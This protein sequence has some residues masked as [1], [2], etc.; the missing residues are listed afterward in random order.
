MVAANNDQQLQI[1]STS[2]MKTKSTPLVFPSIPTSNSSVVCQRGA[3]RWRHLRDLVACVAFGLLTSAG[4]TAQSDYFTALDDTD[5]GLSDLAVAPNGTLIAVGTKYFTEAGTGVV[6]VSWNGGKD[7]VERVPDPQVS[8]Y[9]AV[10]SGHRKIAPATA[11]DLATFEDSI[12]IA[13][14]TGTGRWRVL[15]SLNSG[16]DWEQIEDFADPN[17]V[18]ELFC[19]TMDNEGN[20]YLGGT[21]F[22]S[23]LVT[24]RKGTTTQL[25]PVW[26]VRRIGRDGTKTTSPIPGSGPSYTCAPYGMTC[27]GRTLYVAGIGENHWQV[28][29]SEDGGKT[30]TL[31][32]SA[33]METSDAFGIAAGPDGT[34]YV[35]GRQFRAKTTTVKGKTTTTLVPY[36]IARKGTGLAGSFTTI[37][38]ISNANL[39]GEAGGVT[40]DPSG[41]VHITGGQYL[42]GTDYWLTMRLDA[43]SQQWTTTDRLAGTT[44]LRVKSDAAANIYS[45][46]G[47]WM[48][49]GPQ[50]SAPAE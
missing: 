44:G 36:W 35:V 47:S 11:T 50:P 17:S 43:I 3:N 21:G 42:G 49:R 29:R 48:V 31:I 33:G 23:V 16:A 28:R 20:V 46:G 34:I 13:G 14:H 5:G 26:L 22:E 30:W 8:S 41:N 12:V 24:T 40:V 9:V 6:R 15:R 25:R 7:W 1:R 18:G 32:D 2:P 10:A 45:G 27:V 38:A 39:N 19:A 37:S 4:A